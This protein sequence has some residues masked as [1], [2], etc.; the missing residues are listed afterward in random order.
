[1]IEWLK[2]WYRVV[3]ARQRTRGFMIA[4]SV[5]VLLLSGLT[6]G[7]LVLEARDLSVRRGQLVEAL[8]GQSLRQGDPLAVDLA[9]QGVITVG[10]RTYGDPVLTEQA[11][12]IF[13]PEGVIEY[14]EGLA[15]VL[16]RQT[17]P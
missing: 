15:E 7:R 4:A 12:L 1:M 5:L 2:A 14:P 16:L 13:D 3:D 10:G 8:T 9:E 17:Y 11:D 6:W